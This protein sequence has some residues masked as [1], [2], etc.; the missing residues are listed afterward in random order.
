MLRLSFA[1]RSLVGLLA[2]CM[3][4]QTN[5]SG[6]VLAKG[7]RGGGGRSRTGGGGGGGSSVIFSGTAKKK[8]LAGDVT[9]DV[10]ECPGNCAVNGYCLDKPEPSAREE[11][12]AARMAQAVGLTIFICVM[13]LAWIAT[14]L[15]YVLRPCKENLC[16]NC[17]KGKK[18]RKAEYE[19]PTHK[20]PEGTPIGFWPGEENAFA[21]IDTAPIDHNKI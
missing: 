13:T 11:C 16:P 12:D 21:N 4:L 2:I 7:G 6:L 9:V 1:K 10:S 19:E 17:C 15:L 18:I 8:T 5:N 3:L 14:M 20:N